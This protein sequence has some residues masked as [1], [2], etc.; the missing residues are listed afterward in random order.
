MG[1]QTQE[2]VLKLERGV[3]ETRRGGEDTGLSVDTGLI[4]GTF[5]IAQKMA[6]SRSQALA[7]VGGGETRGSKVPS[8]LGLE[9]LQEV[10]TI[11]SEKQ[12]HCR[13]HQA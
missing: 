13:E 11:F 10:P 4:A 5:C 1:K 3:T 6:P 9:L 12:L 8:H 7:G 2:I